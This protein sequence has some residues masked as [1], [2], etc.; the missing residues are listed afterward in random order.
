MKLLIISI[1][2]FSSLFASEK[3]SL[4]LMWFDQFQ[5]AGYYMAKEKGY[6]KNAGLDVEIKK[7][8]IGMD[9]TKEVVNKRANFAIGRTSLLIDIA[10]GNKLLLLS[11]IFQSSPLVLITKKSSNINTIEDFK[12]KRAMLTGTKKSAGIFAMLSSHGIFQ[13]NMKILK[14][15]NKEQNL[16]NDKVDIISAYLSNQVHTLRQRGIELN[17]FNPKDF[18]FDFYSDFLFTSQDEFDNHPQ[19]VINFRQASLKGWEYAFSHIEEAIDLILKKYNTQHK[20]KSQLFYE[21]IKLKELAYKN[22]TKLG[23]IKIS[24]IKQIYDIYKIMGYIKKDIDLNE[25][26]LHDKRN[27]P[28][29][30]KQEKEWIQKHPV[31]TYSEVNWEPLSIIENN[32]MKGIFGDYL[33]L[34]S[35]KTGLSFKYIPS[36]TWKGAIE[37]FK[38]KE[39]D[40]LPSNPQTL[41]LG[42][43][44]KVYKTYP[45]I[46]VT[47][48]RYRYV[49]NL[50]D[51]INKTIAVPKYYTSYNYL[52]KNYPKIKLLTTK[53]IESALTLVESGKADAFIGH[54][55]TTIYHMTSLNTTNLKIAGTTNFKFKHAYLIQKDFPILLSIINKALDSITPQEKTKIYAKWADTSF[56]KKTNFRLIIQIVL[57]FFVILLFI[58]YRLSQLKKKH[59]VIS[60]LKERLE[61]ALLGNNDGLWDRD[62]TNNTVYRSPRWKEIIGYK[63]E[64]LP[65][66][67]DVW[68]TRVHPDDLSK[69]L[70]AIHDHI[71]GKTKFYENIHR[72]KHKKGHWVWVLDRGKKIN[73]ENSNTLRMI[74]TCTDITKEKEAEIKIK[75][76]QQIIEQI[77]ECVISTDLNGI[78][79]SWNNGAQKLL[80]YTKE[81]I[82][83]SHIGIL[84]N[85]N[86]DK[87]MDRILKQL[88][89]NEKIETELE[90]IKKDKTKVFTESSISVFKDENGKITGVIG[91]IK[92]V[93]EKKEAQKKIKEKEK[94]LLYQANHDALTNLPNRNLLNDRLE[95]SIQRAKRHNE[96]FALFF[97]D[98]DRFKHINDSLGHEIGDLVLKKVSIIIKG[99]LREEDTLARIGGDE[100]VIITG[101]TKENKNFAVLAEKIIKSLQQP[102]ILNYNTLYISTSIGISI[103][104][105]DS[106]SGKNLL[107]FADSAMYKAKE[108][109]RNNYQFYSK[110]M[111]EMAFRKIA[112]ET[113]LRVAIENEEFIVFFQPQINSNKK[114]IE[115]MEALVR[116]EHPVKGLISPD[117]F[118][119]LA[120]DTGMIKEIDKIVMKKAMKQFSKWYEKKL[121]P[122]ILSLNLSMAL[123][124]DKE[125]LK[126]IDKNFRLFN[127]QTDWLKFEV[128]ESQIMKKP[129]NIILKLNTINQAGIGVAV[130]DFG[131]GY[132][133]LSYLKKLPIDTLKIDQS[134]IRYI[135]ESEDDISIVKAIIALAKSMNLELIA[136]GVETKA[137]KEFL[138]KNGCQNIQ[139]YYYSKPLPAVEMEEFL[140]NSDI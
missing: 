41:N 64:E 76:Q 14:S 5:F 115:G 89:Q 56:Q 20:T 16:V 111:T 73:Q 77:N 49:S 11:A 36:K 137:Q 100:F 134:F 35:K 53:D 26:I 32:K 131:T 91:Y 15:K 98:L 31:V 70:K 106:I 75:Y 79:Q 96:K 37:K 126:E 44:S 19:R 103:F 47:N 22:G 105:N 124:H 140:K 4:Q 97:L 125:L 90:F 39:I 107:K 38:N 21:A 87:I 3:V 138:S 83:G 128:T 10:N 66:E 42:L 85:N 68:T 48:N 129:D 92:D 117:S 62:F 67:V 113:S 2:F 51:L 123:L 135:P 18:G 52:V 34:I 133:S 74:G 55:A 118:L 57:L 61:L 136:E 58:L 78:I 88:Q 84:Y 86:D 101:N 27:I 50:D 121:N 25:I 23:E 82:I 120:E 33:N 127:F 116:W 102:I 63:D 65:N 80:G 122:G 40:L 132:S 81:E 54:I 28:Y 9:T 112:M 7:F 139:G 114:T 46:I 71:N 13:N 72:I 94:Q 69:A 24:K 59:S 8:K 119:P 30:N 17:V 108:E 110:E 93:T 6:Y 1:I 130:D 45:M 95:Q 29:L 99:I 109:G 104:P 43:V 12:G 60:K